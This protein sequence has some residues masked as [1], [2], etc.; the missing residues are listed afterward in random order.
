MNM[1]VSQTHGHRF[2][3][4]AIQTP[5]GRTGYVILDCKTGVITN[6]VFVAC[7][8]AMEVAA[9]CEA[10]GGGAANMTPSAEA[11]AVRFPSK[12]MIHAAW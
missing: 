10:H 11:L 12:E 1:C 4:L 3:V 2:G 7:D 5:R 8:I 6:G 9:F